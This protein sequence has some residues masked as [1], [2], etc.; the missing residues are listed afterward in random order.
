[1]K[2]ESCTSTRPSA[3]A[4]INY[5]DLEVMCNYRR[6]KYIRR[7][8]NLPTVHTEDVAQHSFYTA[9]LAVTMAEEYNL[10]VQKHNLEVH[11]YDVEN[12]WERVD[13][14]EVLK[15]ALFHDIE[16]AFTS[17]IPWNVKH[18]NSAVHALIGGI[19]QSKL[20]DIYKDCS[21][22]LRDQMYSKLNSKD[23]LE[24]KFVAIA[25]MME[26]AW[27]CYHESSLGNTYLEDMQAK[28]V[29]VI[30]ADPFSSV[31][32]DTSPMFN[33]MM[34]LLTGKRKA[35]DSDVMNLD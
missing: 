28:A 12:V 8:N 14:P 27:N 19:A 13:V 29:G 9:I 33:A 25:D 18:H 6:L 16:E 11:P 20:Q 4:P 34:H 17:D 7:F 15:K 32:V 1:M 30:Q 35:M 21:S 10:A 23:G 24:G 2:S 3:K 22:T 31:L 26:C 5:N